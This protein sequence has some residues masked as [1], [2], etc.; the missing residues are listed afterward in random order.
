MPQ[1]I[2]VFVSPVRDNPVAQVLIVAMLVLTALDLVFGISNAMFFHQNFS[3]HELRKGLLRKLGNFGML[4]I[5]DVIDGILLS[6]FNF[7]F[8]PIFVTL[9]GAFCLMEIASIIELWGEAHPEYQDTG[10]WRILE[11]TK[12]KAEK[13]GDG[14]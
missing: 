2:D 4:C 13:A 10:V 12:D 5:A 6:G 9:A 7:G 14:K 11:S 3:S 8:Q 1:F